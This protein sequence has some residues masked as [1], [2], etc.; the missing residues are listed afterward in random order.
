M[1]E[2]VTKTKESAARLKDDVDHLIEELTETNSTLE[3]YKKQVRAY[4][5]KVPAQKGNRHLAE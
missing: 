5:R 1:S 2:D 4:S 3:M